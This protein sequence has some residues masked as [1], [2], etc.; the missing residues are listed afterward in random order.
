MTMRPDPERLGG[1]AWGRRTGGALSPAERRLLRAQ[2]AREFAAFLAGSVR[3]IIGRVPAAARGIDVATFQPPD[4][5]LTR[6][7]EEAAAELSPALLAHSYRTWLYGSA[8]AAVD[9]AALDPELF[10][11][12]A[13]LH[14]YGITASGPGRDFTLASAD[15]VMQVCA[16]AGR[17]TVEGELL[18]DAVCAHTT[19]GVTLA[20][21][22]PLTAYT[23]WG[24]LSDAFALRAWDIT[25]GNRRYI[26]RAH[27]RGEFNRE[28]LVVLRRELKNMPNGRFP[29]LFVP[30]F[31]QR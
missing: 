30:A 9:G 17:T 11:C 8:L 5:A 29:A 1:L 6:Q 4:S 16:A 13:L 31:F 21:D 14:D 10:Y 12:T 15:K 28:L 22:G 18:A 3:T 23:Q 2:A 7:T 19:A 20:K 27:P 25:P 26:R 24:A